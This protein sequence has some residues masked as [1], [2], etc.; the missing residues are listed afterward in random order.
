M[1]SNV[2]N[3]TALVDFCT[4]PVAL[5]LVHRLE[6]RTVP[7]ASWIAWWCTG[8]RPLTPRRVVQASLVETLGRERALAFC[9][10]FRGARF[11]SYR[12]VVVSGQRIMTAA[13]PCSDEVELRIRLESL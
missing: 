8:Y 9:H 6:H 12:R 2:I 11:P 4:L 7:P 10:Q 13:S 5:R 1:T 3:R